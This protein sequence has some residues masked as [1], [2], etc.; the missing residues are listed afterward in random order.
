[1]KFDVNFQSETMTFEIARCR[2]TVMRSFRRVAYKNTMSLPREIQL[3]CPRSKPSVQCNAT[4]R[5]RAHVLRKR[6]QLFPSLFLPPECVQFDLPAH[7]SKFLSN[8]CGVRNAF[9]IITAFARA[10]NDL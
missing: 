5:Q 3:A 7:Y 10:A 4:L 2:E 9:C 8:Y 1:M 6:L